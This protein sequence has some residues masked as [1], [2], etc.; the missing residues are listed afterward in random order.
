MDGPSA[1]YLH[2]NNSEK[3]LDEVEH[4]LTQPPTPTILVNPTH[5]SISF[6]SIH[7]HLRAVS[8]FGEQIN[9]TLNAN[10]MKVFAAGW[11][12]LTRK[13]LLI[14]VDNSTLFNPRRDD[15]YHNNPFD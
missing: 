14:S 1:H 13:I 5:H 11:M 10:P 2:L 3:E 9:L 12:N 8:R 15:P 4:L 6:R 7:P